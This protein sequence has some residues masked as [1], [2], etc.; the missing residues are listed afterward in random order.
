MYRKGLKRGKVT[1]DGEE[2]RARGLFQVKLARSRE[3]PN[4]VLD[5]GRGGVFTS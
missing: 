3:N 1:I 2:G 5:G 4:L